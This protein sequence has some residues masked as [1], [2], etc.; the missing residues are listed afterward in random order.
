MGK[1]QTFAGEAWKRK[2]KVTRGK[3]FL[4]EMPETAL[5]RDCQEP[6]ASERMFALANL[7]AVRHRLMPPQASVSI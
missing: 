4:S 6:G 5:S 3:R 1:Q 2:S 7:Y